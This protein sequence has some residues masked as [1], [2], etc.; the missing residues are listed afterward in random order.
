MISHYNAIPNILAHVAYDP[1]ARGQK[2]VKTE[3]VLGL[4]PMSHLYVL[5]VVSH[6]AT[7]RG[8]EIIVLPGFAVVSFLNAIQQF[9]I[10][11]LLVVPPMLITILQKKELCASYD[12]SSVRFVFSGAAPLGEETI[13]DLAKTYPKWQVGQAYG[14]T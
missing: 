8:D 6:T 7:W 13:T 2:G 1:V 11:H 14:M 4:V 9:R 12:L 5:L 3:V 10:E